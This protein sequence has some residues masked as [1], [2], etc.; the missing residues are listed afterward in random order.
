MLEENVQTIL[1]T[2]T[3]VAMRPANINN[4]RNIFSGEKGNVM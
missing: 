2:C 4:V 1:G 3:L